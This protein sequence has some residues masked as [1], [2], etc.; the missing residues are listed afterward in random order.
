MMVGY[1]ERQRTQEVR[2]LFSQS[3]G[4]QQNFKAFQGKDHVLKVGRFNI[5]INNGKELDVLL[6]VFFF[7]EYHCFS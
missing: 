3:V 4:C 6:D 7:F 1:G 5:A 2:G